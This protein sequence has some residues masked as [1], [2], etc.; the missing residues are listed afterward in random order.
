[1]S[2][3][4][5]SKKSV[6][7]GGSSTCGKHGSVHCPVALSPPQHPPR[8]LNPTR[9]WWLGLNPGPA[10]TLSYTPRPFCLFVFYFETGSC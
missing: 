1:M 9:P 8:P 5:E 7:G 10:S 2:A 4:W 3:V 6:P